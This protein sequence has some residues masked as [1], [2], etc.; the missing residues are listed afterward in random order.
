MQRWRFA[1]AATAIAVLT[2]ACGSTVTGVSA[3][4]SG[5]GATLPVGST[6][7]AATTAPDA[8][9]A[10]TPDTS[11]TDNSTAAPVAGA[12]S[13]GATQGSSGTISGPTGAGPGSTVIGSGTQPIK[14]GVFTTSATTG[15]PAVAAFK[16]I[17]KVNPENDFNAVIG[18]YNAHG[19]FGG[20]K[21]TAY[22]ENSSLTASLSFDQTEEAAC[23]KFAED[24][25][26]SFV[27]DSNG[28]DT[29]LTTCLAKVN[30]P[31]FLEFPGYYYRGLFTTTPGELYGVN[32][33]EQQDLLWTWVQALERQGFFTNVKDPKV[34]MIMPG[35]PIGI[36]HIKQVVIPA[37]AKAGLKLDDLASYTVG[38]SA[39]QSQIQSIVLR[40]KKEGITHVI[41]MDA[42]GFTNTY[43]F[44]MDAQ[45][46]NY[47]P[48]QAITLPTLLTSC[49]KTCPRRSSR[50]PW[51]S[52]GSQAWTSVAAQTSP[53]MMRTQSS[54]KPSTQR[55][56]SR[57]QMRPPRARCSG[58]ANSCSLPMPP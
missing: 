26:V 17:P 50:A 34:G 14:I 54:A 56:A 12:P 21:V 4:G 51:G 52:A 57:S 49:V 8:S 10:G 2:A 46:Q 40:F 55:R 36:M 15:D 42:S 1:L 48:R 3:G 5:L 33:P 27:L 18:Y 31:V 13:A 43:D 23:T 30:T 47:Q 25:H 11:G 58:T 41:H 7:G 45:Q 28:A 22:Y 35:T 38:S 19:G 32:F 6:S 44:M 16:S 24:D 53:P 20:H 37:L 9:T 39:Q 29:V